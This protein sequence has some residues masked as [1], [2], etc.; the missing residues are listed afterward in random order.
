MPGFK[1][2]VARMG[3]FEWILVGGTVVLVLLA[4]LYIV[5]LA[6]GPIW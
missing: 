5:A 6:G 1:A 2:T 4:V 3:A